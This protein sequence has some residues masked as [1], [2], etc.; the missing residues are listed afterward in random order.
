MMLFAAV[1]QRPVQTLAGAV[2]LDA[3]LTSFEGGL[4]YFII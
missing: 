4:S 1:F 2:L 3:F